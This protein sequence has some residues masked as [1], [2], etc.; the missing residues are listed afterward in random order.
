MNNFKYILVLVAGIGS[1]CSVRAMKLHQAEPKE[2][3][4]YNIPHKDLVKLIKDGQSKIKS[5]PQQA[6]KI[7]QEAYDK[8]T[9]RWW[10][11]GDKDG[12]L[13]MVLHDNFEPNQTDIC[14]VKI[15][16]FLLH[17]VTL[18]RK[19]S[20]GVLKEKSSLLCAYTA[21][22]LATA[23]AGSVTFAQDLDVAWEAKGLKQCL[24]VHTRAEDLA[25]AT[26]AAHIYM[27]NSDSH[28]DEVTLENALR[29][30]RRLKEL[31]KA[32]IEAIVMQR[33]KWLS[34]I[35]KNMETE[36]KSGE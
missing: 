8:T 15:W 21:R 24:W 5:E 1:F 27:E 14:D 22:K 3:P 36:K 20:N 34:Q 25:I 10:E 7:L 28:F 13:A 2:T 30:W 9:L 23:Y 29:E 19:N 6:L 18:L 33:E 35:P 11:Y 4:G 16:K 26:N 32:D 12:K 31:K 17:A